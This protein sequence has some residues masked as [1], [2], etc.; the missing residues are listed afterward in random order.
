MN[1]KPILIEKITPNSWNPNEMTSEEFAELVQEVKHLG[2]PPKPIV[3]REKGDGIEIVDGE[4]SYKALKELGIKELKS[5][6]YELVS[7]DDVE[8]K[9]QTYKR[10]LGG[11]N[12]PVKLGLMIA[13]ALAESNLSNRKLAE[14]WEISEGMIRNYL[15]YAEAGKLRKDY[16]NIAKCTTEQIRTYLKIAEYAQPIADYWLSLGGLKD[17]L[18][19]LDGNVPFDKANYNVYATFQKLCDVITKNNY[20]KVLPLKGTQQWMRQVQ[21]AEDKEKYINEFKN[22]FNRALNASQLIEKMKTYFVWEETVS[23]DYILEYL[24]IY[25]N[26]YLVPDHWMH[27]VFSTAIRK[28]DTKYEMLLTPEEIK[29][30]LHYEYGK[31]GFPLIREKLKEAIKKKH[32]IPTFQIKE[33]SESLENKLARAEIEANAPEFI[34]TSNELPLKLV[35]IFINMKFENDDRRKEAW[36]I[37]VANYRSKDFEKIGFAN[38]KAVEAKIINILDEVKTEKERRNEITTLLKL[39]EQELAN[40]F[41]EKLHRLFKGDEKVK[42]SLSEKMAVTFSKEFLIVFMHLANKYYA[43]QEIKERIRVMMQ[44]MASARKAEASK[45]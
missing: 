36:E 16:A 40:T 15:L 10:N 20:H 37:L 29:E 39:S 42:K 32:N 31:E 21:S 3:V 43:E 13:K 22:N 9:R 24:A 33:S 1:N 18:L 26:T 41:V 45:K 11:K 44:E 6:W 30:C 28:V 5:E 4:H 12:N 23:D 38:V 19:V 17:A 35:S 7:L 27:T 25:Y 14:Q 8:A 2:K 34:K